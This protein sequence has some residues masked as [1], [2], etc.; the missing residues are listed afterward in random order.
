ML[1]RLIISIIIL[2]CSF[3]LNGQIDTIK[4]LPLGNSITQGED[5]SITGGINSFNT[6][7]RILWHEL[8]DTLGYNVDFIGSLNQNYPCGAYDDPDFDMDHEGHWAWT[9]D[10]IVYGRNGSCNGS[11]RL[12]QWVQSVGIPDIALV[13]LGT[14]DCW[15]G[16]STS[17]TITEMHA[18]IDTLRSY[19]P[20]MT[21]LL[22]QIIGHQSPTVQAA[23]DDLN[24][25]IPILA[26]SLSTPISKIIVVDQATGFNP[27]TDLYDSAHPNLAGETKMAGKFLEALEPILDSLTIVPGDLLQYMQSHI[28][29]IPDAGDNNFTEPNTQESLAWKEV[30]SSA[31]KENWTEARGVALSLDY[32]IVT[33]LDTLQSKQYLILERTST[34]PHWGAYVFNPNACRENLVLMAPHSRYDTNTGV[35]A[36]YCFLQTDSYALMLSGT[37]RCNRDTYSTCSGLTSVCGS[38]ERFRISD[39]AHTT[40]SAWQKTVEILADSLPE[41]YFI[42]LHGFAK[43]ST[44]PYVIMSNGTRVTPSF[45]PLNEMARY[46]KILDPVLTFKIGHIDLSWSRLLGFT[47]T[48]SR[49]IN[50]SNNPCSQS[51]T[52]SEGR[53]LHIEQEITRLR[54]DV[55]GWDKI[56]RAIRATWPGNQCPSVVPKDDQ[57]IWYIEKDQE[58]DAKTWTSAHGD[59]TDILNLAN[60]GDSVFISEGIYVPTDGLDQ[61]AAF[62][63]R[64]G[65]SL[66]GGFPVGGSAFGLRN[67]I[68]FPVVLSGDIGVQNVA[69]DDVFQTV[70]I[71]FL[72][73][74]C[75]LDGI[76]IEPGIDAGGSGIFVGPGAAPYEVELKGVMIRN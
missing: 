17:S 16:Q 54:Q 18:M 2:N 43:R 25:S 19:N 56:A 11:G 40:T 24:D 76:E 58:G 69:L 26:A 1:E 20:K 41:S 12:G 39:L 71:L 37:H 32:R 42:Q 28:N 3:F 8:V 72:D 46:L 4:I 67:S 30:I 29:S 52:V 31:L 55:F 21:I 38:S 44:D 63:I 57:T 27:I 62:H 50:Q 10:E 15:G 47:N 68:G 7:R 23:I 5:A 36:T 34:G 9:V 49:Y 13:H 14:N 74:D 45:D 73:Q 51:A 33:F 75:V 61:N 64:T 60:A 53:F 70:K 66:F 48:N 6:Y 22:S 35:E 59:L 65:I